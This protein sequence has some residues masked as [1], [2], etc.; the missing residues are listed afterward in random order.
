MVAVF[1]SLLCEGLVSVFLGP[2]G[3]LPCHHVQCFV[4]SMIVRI[5]KAASVMYGKGMGVFGFL[6]KTK[7]MEIPPPCVVVYGLLQT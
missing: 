1:C 4:T 6:V 5:D 3:L 7:D 2:V